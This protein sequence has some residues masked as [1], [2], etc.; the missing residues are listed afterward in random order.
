MGLR[1]HDYSHGHAPK[2]VTKARRW[3]FQLI[4]SV[5]ARLGVHGCAWCCCYMLYVHTLILHRYPAGTA[6]VQYSASE[7]G[8]STVVVGPAWTGLALVQP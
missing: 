3:Q 1:A 4:G 5:E 7:R 6:E 8:G 2:A